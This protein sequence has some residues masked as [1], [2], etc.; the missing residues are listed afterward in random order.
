MALVLN[1]NEVASILTMKD[2]IDVVEQSFRDLAE[3]NADMPL[4]PTIRVS[5]PPGLI[6]VM[7]AYLGK[8]R[9][10][11]MK[12]VSSYLENP[13]KF[14]IPTVQAT[15][16]YCD[17]ESGQ[18]LA[19]MD[20]GYITAVRTGAASGVATKYLARPNSRIIGLLGSGIQAETQLQAV[21]AVR[22][23]KRAQV[24]SPTPAHR[25]SFAERMS[26]K[27]GIEII[28]VDHPAEAVKGCDI[29]IA[30][31]SAKTPIVSGDWLSPGTHINAIGS[32]AANTRELD[33]STIKRSKVVVD[34]MEAALR[35]GGDILI[36]IADGVIGQDHIYGELGELVIGRKPG[37]T[38]ND[39][40][41]LF[42]S[43]GLAIEDV[44]TA[45]LVYE[46]AKSQGKGVELTI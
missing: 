8:M 42:K 33:E 2:A 38:T 24:F 27:L 35:E 19:I 30:A 23:I 40:I 1:R 41:T 18:L 7:P 14:G 12:L 13:V 43:H 17:S 29:V 21:C 9:A 34:S 39:E 15:I 46:K 32:H 6:N 44:S 10:L 3:G 26:G 20:G 36:P 25:K 22:E 31:S 28:P 45:K 5:Q 16:L 37:R 4:R 11:G